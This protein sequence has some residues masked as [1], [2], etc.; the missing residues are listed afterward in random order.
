MSRIEIHP[1]YRALFA[2]QGLR[3]AEDFLRLEG[4]ILGGHPDRHVLRLTLGAGKSYSVRSTQP[5]EEVVAARG[6]STEYSVP[7]TDGQRPTRPNGVLLPGPEY[8]VT[9]TDGQR[10]TRPNGVLL[11]GSEYSV[12]STDGQRPARPNGVLLPGSE[13]SVLGTEAFGVYLKKEHHV[14]W[15]ERLAHAWLGLGWI[16]KSAREGRMLRLV[17]RAGIG[18]PRALAWG[19]AQGRAFLLLRE[20]PDAADLREYL[21]AHPQ[22]RPEIAA[23]LAQA[24]ARIHDAGF[25][26][27]DLSSKHVLIGHDDAGYRFCFLDWQRARRLGRVSWHH[28]LMDLAMLDATLA[29]DCAAPRERLLFWNAYLQASV[30]PLR[31]CFTT[32]AAPFRARRRRR[33]KPAATVAKQSLSARSHQHALNGSA[34]ERDVVIRSAPRRLLHVLCRLS[35]RLQGKRRIRELRQAPLPA[36]KQNLIWLDGEALCVTR[37][38]LDEVGAA[39]GWLQSS[40]T[41]PARNAVEVSTF[42]GTNGRSWRLVRHWSHRPVHWLLH[43]W[44][45][46]PFPAPE[47]EHAAAI[48]RLERYGVEVPR[49]LALGHRSVRPW[50]KESFLLVEPPADTAP[51]FAVLETADLQKRRRLLREA[52]A[53]WRRIHEAG[54]AWGGHILTPL[55][56][57]LTTEHLV[58]TGVEWLQRKSGTPQRLAWRDFRLLL[59]AALPHVG[60]TDRLRFALGYFGRERATGETGKLLRRLVKA[61]R[62]TRR[63]R[64]WRSWRERRV[65]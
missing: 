52:G 8:S 7:S 55:A 28:R 29:A 6:T 21:Q 16:S 33:L 36:G 35:A 31:D 18:C 24:V 47:F 39:P 41:G 65:V 46:E 19:E 11:P 38:F 4:E 2:D 60:A 1:A 51:L 43:L 17:E 57:C 14:S 23:A 56:T 3:A 45:R 13:H 54:Y 9:S 37:Q 32:V 49:L 27:R 58:L 63:R 44:R 25:F 10:P 5:K 15:R 48:I 61:S 40:G 53:L 34:E 30:G 20:E 42:G 12:T 26:H 59:D 64:A 50:R 22:E 62:R